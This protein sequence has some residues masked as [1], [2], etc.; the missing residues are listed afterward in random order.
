[1]SYNL[2]EHMQ[3]LGDVWAKVTRERTQMDAFA[4]LDHTLMHEVCSSWILALDQASN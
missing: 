3:G 4:L 2:K 1:M